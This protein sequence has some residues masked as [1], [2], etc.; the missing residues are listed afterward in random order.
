MDRPPRRTLS[1]VV[2]LFDEEA[3][4]P[5]LAAGLAA[6]VDRERERREVEVLLVDD[7]STD[8]THALLESHVGHWPD[9][10]ILRHEQNLGLTAALFTGS[11]AARGDAVAWLDGDLSYEPALLADLVDEVDRGADLACASCYHPDGEVEG[12][13]AWRLALSKTASAAWRLLTHGQLHT[14]TSMV[15]VWRRSIVLDCR[16]TRGGYLGVTES[17]LR[18]LVAGAR[19]VEVPAVLGRRRGGQSKMRVARVAL[20]QLGLM[21]AWLGGR[22]RR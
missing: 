10:R 21:A 3:S 12:V 13:P 14:Y 8:H 22:V 17:L 4:V 9:T 2:P 11:H 16:P 19:V 5:A 6:F 15:R 1:I 20:G 7:G 18:A